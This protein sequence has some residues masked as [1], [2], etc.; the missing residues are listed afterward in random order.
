[1][2]KLYLLRWSLLALIMTTLCSCDGLISSL[3]G[4]EDE[5]EDSDNVE[6]ALDLETI[7]LPYEGGSVDIVYGSAEYEATTF[8]E[9]SDQK[10]YSV[11]E[12]RMMGS[13]ELSFSYN[14]YG[15]YAQS[16]SFST[17]DTGS[18][19]S[20]QVTYQNGDKTVT[21]PIIQA[22]ATESVG[23]SISAKSINYEQ[24]RSANSW[25]I[26]DLDDIGYYNT[27]A[28]AIINSGQYLYITVTNDCDVYMPNTN[29]PNVV[30]FA[31]TNATAIRSLFYSSNLKEVYFPKVS[32][33]ESGVFYEPY[34]IEKITLATESSSVSIGYAVFG[35]EEDFSETSWSDVE[36]I[37]G[38]SNGSTINGKYW[39]VNLLADSYSEDIT[40]TVGPFKSING[41]SL[42]YGPFYLSTLPTSISDIA[43]DVIE[44]IDEDSDGP[45]IDYSNL[46]T[47][48]STLSGE[49]YDNETGEMYSNGARYISI[50]FPNLTSINCSF[51]DNQYIKSV[52]MPNNER[53]I[54]SSM[55]EGCTALESVY[56]PKSGAV[57]ESGFK[58][59]SSLTSV[60]VTAAYYLYGDAF[61]G[62]S[63]L[64]T[65]YL[66][67]VTTINEGAFA[68]CDALNDLTLSTLVSKVYSYHPNMFGSSS[69]YTSPSSI[70][71]T[72]GEDDSNNIEI[73]GLC[74]TAPYSSYTYDVQYGPFA[75][76]N[77][78][79]YDEKFSGPFTLATIPS[80]G[81]LIEGDVW[82]ITDATAN[83]GTYNP[84]DEEGDFFN[85]TSALIT[86][87]RDIVIEFTSL[88]SIPSGAF[89]LPDKFD[90]RYYDLSNLVEVNMPKVKTIGSS[91]FSSCTGLKSIYAPEVTTIS[92]FA[93]SHCSALESVDMPAL[94][95]ID[96]YGFGYA[97]LTSISLPELT[98]ANAYAFYKCS[99]LLTVELP[100]LEAF[101]IYMFREC[102]KLMTVSAESA[103]YVNYGAFYNCTTLQNVTMPEVTELATATKSTTTTQ[104]GVFENCSSLSKISLPKLETIGSSA[105]RA[106]TSLTSI[107][108]EAVTSVNS[109]AFYGSTALVSVNMPQ[110]KTAAAYSFCGC[111]SLSEIYMPSLTIASQYSFSGCVLKSVSLPEVTNLGSGVFHSNPM[112]SA[113]LPKITYIGTYTFI[114]C[115]YLT[116]LTLATEST[117]LTINSNSFPEITLANI[118]LTTGT[119][120]GSTI[121]GNTLTTSGGETF[122][123]KSITTVE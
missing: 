64:E 80:N 123:F 69:S 115:I 103:T 89:E 68:K 78:N 120:N 18:T 84:L 17:N 51:S 106:C 12:Y 1:M 29:L 118:D 92:T 42:S 11:G 122:T 2:N 74:F 100:K 109:H 65:L 102:S 73:I 19:R 111:E 41:N 105:L 85:L 26:S 10:W 83:Y 61:Y 114:N 110:L 98:T 39:S 82:E 8:F 91:A 9:D 87:D 116:E 93:F 94:T 25:I 54:I 67:N 27:L 58:D 121:E 108:M 48:L 49:G 63:S 79:A 101:P 14:D 33:I 72:I 45:E 107:D 57:Y 46:K 30:S 66:P 99:S 22:S 21:L 20:S 75:S 4:D 40:V 59:C 16:I 76:I 15:Y 7:Y 3:L 119:L 44:I 13:D 32:E 53:Q 43:G 24:I 35:A 71:L 86:A 95:S 37:T 28:D 113:Y 34:N 96:T 56:S 6:V 77:G 62:C 104:Y 60:D 81:L 55:F 88:E 50:E 36:L 47:L 38:E 70:A 112:T 97:G 90:S 31:A 117:S 23:A 52:S 5:D